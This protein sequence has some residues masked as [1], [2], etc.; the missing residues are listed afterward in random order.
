MDIYSY[1]RETSDASDVKPVMRFQLVSHWLYPISYEDSR[2]LKPIQNFNIF[3][4]GV[5]KSARNI[6]YE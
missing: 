6:Y 3:N 1:F 5:N 2:I 4:S